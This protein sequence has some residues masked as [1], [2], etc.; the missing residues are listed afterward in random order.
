MFQRRLHRFLPLSLRDVAF[1][2]SAL[3]R[4]APCLAAPCR[5]AQRL[6]L[7]HGGLPCSALS[8]SAAPCRAAPCLTLPCRVLPCHAALCLRSMTPHR[9]KLELCF[10]SLWRATAPLEPSSENN[11]FPTP[12][13]ASCYTTSSS[14][15][16]KA[17]LSS[18]AITHRLRHFHGCLGFRCHIIAR[19]H[20]P[21]RAF[22]VFAVTLSRRHTATNC[23]PLP[24]APTFASFAAI[25][26]ANLLAR[27]LPLLRPTLP[28][29]A[30]A[31]AA[32]RCC[33]PCRQPLHAPH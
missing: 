33:C 14:F 13:Y 25:R 12:V 31:R 15:A 16:Y 1:R 7:R 17:R 21:R 23:L 28:T 11:R 27:R 8:C 19:H 24:F 29:V 9:D 6:A 22:I 26:V 10:A 20:P 2:C 18:P 32:N 5:V 4:A 30:V 3:C